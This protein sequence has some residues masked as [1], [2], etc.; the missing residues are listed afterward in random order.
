MQ[1]SLLINI[2][3]LKYALLDFKLNY[4]VVFPFIGQTLVCDCD[5]SLIYELYKMLSVTPK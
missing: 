4:D 5:K 2:I 1:A 3:Y